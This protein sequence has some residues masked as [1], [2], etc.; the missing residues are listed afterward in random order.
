MLIP[1]L[2]LLAAFLAAAASFAA[3]MLAA[4]ALATWLRR[5][6]GRRGFTYGRHRATVLIGG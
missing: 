6:P 1:L 5:R 3:V 4:V 2:T